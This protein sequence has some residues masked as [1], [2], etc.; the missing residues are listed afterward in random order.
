MAI[1]NQLPIYKQG[2]DLLSLAADVQ[3][4]MPRSFKASLGAKIH[5]ECVEIL[6]LIG[7][8]NAARGA[9]RAPHIMAIVERLEVVTLLLRLGFDK[10]F[11]SL[12]L[13]SAAVLLTE[14][15]G[16]QA[17]GWLKSSRFSTAV[18]APA[19]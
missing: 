13:W 16:K 18:T 3:Q 4:N 12:K 15:I 8:A 1:H 10:R 19:A 17:G 14:S 11:V 5:N 2:Y 7:R 9:G 6:V